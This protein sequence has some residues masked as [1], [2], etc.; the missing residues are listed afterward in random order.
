ML[1][2]RSHCLLRI[3]L[4]HWCLGARSGRGNLCNV[5]QGHARCDDEDACYGIAYKGDKAGLTPT[6]V[7]MKS[8]CTDSNANKEWN[9][10]LKGSEPL[11]SG[12]SVGRP[13]FVGAERPIKRGWIRQRTQIQLGRKAKEERQKQEG[14]KEKSKRSRE[15][16]KKEKR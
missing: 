6:K 16:E 9:H 8:D 14:E 5:L 10:S 1:R 3:H 11:P 13:A 4:A 2:V 15:S 12:R 7:Y